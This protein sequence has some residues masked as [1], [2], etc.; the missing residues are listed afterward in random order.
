MS[1]Q[2]PGDELVL[3]DELANEWKSTRRTL[4]RYDRLSDG[5]PFVMIAG[6]KYRPLKA[7][8]EWLA[9]RIRRPNSSSRAR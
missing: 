6:R 5:L 3:D 7:C 2:I 8:R 4:G 9:R 1:I